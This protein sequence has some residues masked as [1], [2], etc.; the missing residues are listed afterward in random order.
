M[1]ITFIFGL[2][3]V[4]VAVFFVDLLS[5]WLFVWA[6]TGATLRLAISMHQQSQSTAK[7]ARLSISGQEHTGNRSA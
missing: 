7:E 3:S 2:L 6:Y 1:L 5:P 4:L